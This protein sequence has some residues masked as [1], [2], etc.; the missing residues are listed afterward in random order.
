MSIL[1]LITTF[2]GSLFNSQ[3]Q[4]DLENLALRQQVTMLWQS[5]KRH[6]ATASGWSNPYPLSTPGST[7]QPDALDNP[8][9]AIPTKPFHPITG[10]EYFRFAGCNWGFLPWGRPHT[11]SQ[12]L[13]HICPRI[14]RTRDK[15]STQVC[16][17]ELPKPGHI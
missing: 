6:R 2:L 8:T 3:R 17:P 16:D 13:Q 4:L 11:F 5:V 10:V 1:T 9:Q 14:Q 15:G 7:N 12:S